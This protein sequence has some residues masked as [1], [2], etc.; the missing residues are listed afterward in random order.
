MRF[1][2]SLLRHSLATDMTLELWRFVALPLDVAPHRRPVLVLFV[3]PYADEPL[4]VFDEVVVQRAV[5]KR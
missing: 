3:A 2:R 5:R 4:V 1:Q